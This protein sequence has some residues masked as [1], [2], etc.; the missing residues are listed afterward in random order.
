MIVH[1]LEQDEYPAVYNLPA[2]AGGEFYGPLANLYPE[3]GANIVT[4]FQELDE[5]QQFAYADGIQVF[6]ISGSHISAAIRDRLTR[7]VQTDPNVRMLGQLSDPNLANATPTIVLGL[8]LLNRTH[9]DLAGFYCEVIDR[10]LQ[11]VPALAVVIDGLNTRPWAGTS[12]PYR[13]SIPQHGDR[14]F[15]TEERQAVARIH[16]HVAGRPVTVVDCVGTLMRPNLFWIDRAQMFVAPWGAGLVKYR[17]VCN[18]PGVVFSSRGNLS[19]P[20]HLPIYHLPQF[21]ED[22]AE[23]E[24][25]SPDAV[26]DLHPPGTELDAEGR[27]GALRHGALSPVNFMLDSAR[28]IEQIAAMFLRTLPEMAARSLADEARL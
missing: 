11:D 17:W 25:V 14:D 27:D 26:T 13:V 10:L 8:R 28:V 15:L 23:I 19:Q 7:A 24:Y 16:A 4:A 9:H 6:R 1:E 20:H 3:L 12:T 5:L 22:P 18:K 21:M 2:L